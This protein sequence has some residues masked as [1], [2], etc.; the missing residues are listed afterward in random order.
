LTSSSS[1]NKTS[2]RTEVLYGLENVMNTIL[3]FLS[4][5]NTIN[6]CGDYKAPSAIIKVEE[7]RKLLY[8]LKER[9]IKLRYIT[10][11]TKDNVKYCKELIN[12]FAYEIRHIDGIKANFS[13]SET[14]YL[15][16]ATL[17]KEEELQQQPM[18]P[19]Q[20]VIYSNVKDIVEQQKYV[21]DSFW[22]KA[23]PADHRIKEIEEGF[24]LSNTEVIQIPSR[25]KE[26]F[27]D[28]IRS[29]K[30]EVLL[31]LPTTNAFL[32]EERIGVIQLLRE[33]AAER[34]VNVRILTPINNK[35]EKIIQNTVM[36]DQANNFFDIRAIET[37]TSSPEI[38]VVG[39]VTIVVVDRKQS[40]VIEKTDDSKE[41]F[42]DAVG[43]ATYSTSKPTV[44]S[45]ISIFDSL[46]KQV[47]LYEELKT[48]GRMQGEFINIASHELRTPTQSV[49]AYSELLRRHPE[50]RDEMIQAIYRN[51]ERLQRL[52]NDILDVTKI[53]SQTL[54]LNKEKFNLSGLLSNIVQDYKNNI[55]KS[56]GKVRLLYN[57][58]NK[59]S[60]IVEA[61]R[62]RITQVISNL[63]NNAV[64]FTE[65]T[66]GDVYVAAA[67]EMEKADQK[68]VVVTIK[69]R[70]IGIDSEI[71]PRLFTKFATRSQAG[72][73]LGLFI[74]KSIIEAHG[75][76]I[77]AENNKDGKG[78]A[79]FAFSLPLSKEHEEKRQPYYQIMRLIGQINDE[80]E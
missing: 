65:E 56:N 76:K 64:K 7:Y 79:T 80:E 35:V 53:E 32:R 4:K 68:V 11:I 21:F 46:S 54:K 25:T 75:G 52:T 63:L 17:V 18:R 20:Q 29:A 24:V 78:G 39:T 38:A 26:L 49:L 12:D 57:Q 48:H 58:P 43:L 51:A 42:I 23:I 59:D 3:Q 14:E 41:E 55:E 44:L 27:I 30:E 15:A 40:L 77:W 37:I 62:E 36:V 67:E 28:L 16:Y 13:V 69:D 47:K 22:N 9:G 66:R 60:F 6:S 45:Y 70:G 61:D 31:L 1:S 5:A 74:C 2:E 73:G 50:R 8:D 34:R 33:A 71:S 10:D 72:T 19:I